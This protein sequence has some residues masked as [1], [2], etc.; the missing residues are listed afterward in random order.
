MTKTRNAVGKDLLAFFADRLKAHLREEGARLDLIE[1]VFSL[2]GEDDVVLNVK[3]FEALDAVF[4]TDVGLSLLSGVKRA[5]T[6]LAT[7]ETKDAMSY[8]GPYD[9]ALL[10]EEEELALAAAIESMKQELA[11]AV[12]REDFAAALR[13][14]AELRGPINS[15]F[16]TVTVDAGDAALR[17]N[18]LRLLSQI[19]AASLNVADFTNIA[20]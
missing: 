7:E 20:G 2:G 17:R 6:V 16:D 13:A 3:R 1:A 12:E 15:F 19:R 5:Q 18:R 4:K 11:A 14:L 9:A 10:K 8:A